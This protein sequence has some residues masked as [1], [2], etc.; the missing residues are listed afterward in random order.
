[1]NRNYPSERNVPG[2][3]LAMQKVETFLQ[4]RKTFSKSQKK[5]LKGIRRKSPMVDLTGFDIIEGF[6]PDY[7]HACLLGVG[8]RITEKLLSKLKDEDIDYMGN[9]M[10]NLKVPH[11]LAQ[12]PRSLALRHLWKAKEWEAWVLYYSIP[13]LSLKL[14]QKYI[15]YWSLFSNSL[16]ILL[17]KKIS[18]EEI[19]SVHKKLVRFV[20]LT[21]A[22]FGL[23]EMTF[24]LHQLIHLA[25]SVYNWGPLFSHACFG[26]E[27]SN[28]NLVRAVKSANGVNI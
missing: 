2:T 23:S 26:F 12:L 10:C 7:M 14:K 21:E 28:H 15:D 8:K 1:M 13:I 27:N 18:F 17:N 11:Q 5:L 20:T 22:H 25:A 16:Y 9:L 19:E 3:L 6:T 24:N 4:S